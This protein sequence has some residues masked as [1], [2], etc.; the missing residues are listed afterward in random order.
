MRVPCRDCR[1]KYERTLRFGKYCTG[2]L[3]RRKTLSLLKQQRTTI[4]RQISE[5]EQELKK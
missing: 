4:T 2:C 3:K 5:I 1:I